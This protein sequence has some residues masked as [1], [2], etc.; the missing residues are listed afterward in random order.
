[1][2][3]RDDKPRKTFV[4]LR[5]NYETPGE[6][7]EPNTPK[8]L[9][10]LAA[11]ESADRPNRL[12]LAKWLVSAEHPLTAR[13][14]VNRYWQL[15]FGRG[16][17]STP[18]DFGLQGALPTHPDLLDWLAV[19]FRESG[20]DVKSLLKGMALSGAYRQ[21][22]VAA[23]EA[24][25][26]DPDNQWF[27][28]GPRLRLD[29]RLLRDQALA[30]SGLLNTQIGG[31][32]VSPYQPDG[33]WEAMSLNKNRYLRDDGQDLYRRSLYTVWRRVVAPA[34]FFD[35]PS[36]QSCTVTLTRT[37]TPLHAPDH[38]QRCHLRR[39]GTHVGGEACG[40]SRRS[41]TAVTDVLFRNSAP[42]RIA[43]AGV[44]RK[45]A[46]RGPRAIRS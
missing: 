18:D 17:V 35:V 39:S 29:S 38:A 41:R 10:P 36:R 4:L 24:H 32:P 12:D 22:A 20:W 19:E 6:E 11:D 43:G 31:P 28:R 3:M 21:S 9:P 27:A 34:N 2:V 46:P 5:G 45:V 40:D 15:M 1:M 26:D 37:S 30:L 13:V 7:V 42:S 16:L 23:A 44:T 25:L 8:F 33:I 14:T